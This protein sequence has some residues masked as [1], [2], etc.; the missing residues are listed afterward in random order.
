ML[1]VWGKVRRSP[2]WG[3]MAVSCIGLGTQIRSRSEEGDNEF[4]FG[5]VGN[6]AQSLLKGFLRLEGEQTRI[7]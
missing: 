6:Q 1:A 3:W 7:N 2:V 4:H 5:H